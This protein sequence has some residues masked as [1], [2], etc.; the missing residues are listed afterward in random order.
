MLMTQLEEERTARKRLNQQLLK[1]EAELAIAEERMKRAQEKLHELVP[2]PDSEIAAYQPDGKI[3]LIDKSAKIVHINLGS[4]DHVYRGLTFSV[5]DKNMPI[6]KD[7][8]GKAEIEVFNAGKN[9]SA[10]RICTK[11][12]FCRRC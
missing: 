10:Y 7:G 1:T 12:M 3:I 8:E 5:Y 4:E 6:P 11:W 2:P 9:I